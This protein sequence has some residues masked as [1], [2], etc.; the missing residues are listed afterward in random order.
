ME[1][2]TT[3]KG[4]GLMSGTSL[5]GLDVVYCSFTERDEDWSFK[6]LNATTIQYD[7]SIKTRLQSSTKI[8]GFELSLLDTDFG[9][10][11]A[12]EV[13]DLIKQWGAEPQFIASH[14]HTVFHQPDKGFTLQIG[15]PHFL[16]EETGVPIIYDFRSQDVTLGGQ[17][18]PLVP[19]GDHYL[20]NEYDYCLNLGGIAN[21]SYTRKGERLAF[22]I[23]PCNIPLN[24]LAQKIGHEYDANGAIASRGKI[25]KK[26]FEEL[27]SLSYYRLGGAKSLGI[28]WVQKNIFPLLDKSGIEI[29][30]LL[31]TMTEHTA[32]QIAKAIEGGS[33]LVTGGGAYNEYLIDRIKFN[34]DARADLILPSNELINFKEALIFA[35][36]GILRLKGRVNCLK[37]VTG[38]ISDSCSGSVIGE[39][40][41]LVG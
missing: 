23:V 30:D 39:L 4:I 25:D 10:L 1:H 35:F 38:A 6:I 20:F 7:N 19:V 9:K 36:L 27:N 14:G 31:A 12:K 37:S 18:A 41:N 13:I 33:V 34:I 29:E 26:L 2:S 3:Y 22:D 24:S 32:Y 11:L 16:H 8:Q 17:G 5:D 28:E 21:V 40:Q 15:N